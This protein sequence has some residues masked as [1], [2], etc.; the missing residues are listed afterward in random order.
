MQVKPYLAWALFHLIHAFLGHVS[1]KSNVLIF[2]G[3]NDV[4][5][6]GKSPA[7]GKLN[8]KIRPHLAY[9]SVLLIFWFSAGRCFFVF[10]LF[11]G[12]FGF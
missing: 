5:Q 12:D 1:A 2:S 10:K 9:T 8:V 7:P 4:G 11:S 3:V 6:R